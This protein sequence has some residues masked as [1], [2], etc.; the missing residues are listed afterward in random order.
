VEIELDLP[1]FRNIP[2]PDKGITQ[3]DKKILSTTI[4][5]VLAGSMA[6]AANADVTLYGQIDVSMDSVD[7]DGA[8]DEIT[9]NSNASRLGVKG[10]EDLGNGLSAIFQLE[11]EVNV[12]G[13]NNTNGGGNGTNFG[14][15][16]QSE[17]ATNITGGRDQWVG[18]KG[19]FGK[20]RFGTMSTQYKSTGSSVDPLWDTAFDTRNTSMQSSL[21]GGSGANGQG[22]A[23]KTVGYDTADFNGLSAGATYSFD[24]CGA[25]A[26]CANDD[27]SYS[28]GAKYKNGPALVFV[29]YVTSDQGGDDD[30]WKI[31]GSYSFGDA[32]LYAQ[33]EVDG[34]LIA[35]GVPGSGA[36]LSND[37]ADL[38]MLGG[39]YTMGNAMLVAQFAQGDD[40]SAAGNTEYDSWT[41]AGVYNFSK[42][43]KTYVGFNQYSEDAT[44]GAELDHFAVGMAHKF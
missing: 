1:P 15:G 7:I 4:A 20:V 36:G 28:L 22:R 12:T 23:T 3:M 41:L 25:A 2:K 30:A 21:H 40:D 27:D 8:D 37:G 35:N 43:T 9:M 19:G 34:G 11:Y 13:G 26:S 24:N 31:G 10:S 42:R 18:L 5:G 33:Y 39:S 6:F 16:T 29:D 38:W 44:G 17:G 14:T 32:A